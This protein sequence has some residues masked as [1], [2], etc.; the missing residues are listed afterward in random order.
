MSA[1]LWRKQGESDIDLDDLDGFADSFGAQYE[2]AFKSPFA[3]KKLEKAFA[4]VEDEET[5]EEIIA[6]LG[7]AYL[8][9]ALL[10]LELKGQM[11]GPTRQDLE[12]KMLE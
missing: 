7:K 8:K 4:L 6:K 3:K 2:V 12:E 9:I 11:N 5:D 1:R 10:G